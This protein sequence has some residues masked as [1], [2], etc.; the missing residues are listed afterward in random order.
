M[1]NQRLR[2]SI[3]TYL[4]IAASIVFAYPASSDKI[5]FI[6]RIITAAAIISAYI[7][8]VINEKPLPVVLISASIPA[9]LWVAF[10]FIWHAWMVKSGYTLW[11]GGYLVTIGGP[12]EVPIENF[13]LLS[14][15]I[16]QSYIIKGD[17]GIFRVLSYVALTGFLFGAGSYFLQ[18]F[19]IMKGFFIMRSVNINMYLYPLKV[20]VV[21]IVMVLV[22]V[23]LYYMFYLI[24]ALF[25]K[26]TRK[27]LV[28][29]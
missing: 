10:E 29:Q 4:C 22:C 18:F 11:E 23:I 2:A 20:L 9:F 21:I 6:F 14:L 16:I 28:K 26:L 12:V 13:I 7:G 1:Q 27:G 25:N 19:G 5:D 17:K 15:I 8:F 24:L 3:T